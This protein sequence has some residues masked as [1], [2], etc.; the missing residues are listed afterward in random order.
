LI[1]GVDRRLGAPEAVLLVDGDGV[2]AFARNRLGDNRR[3]QRAPAGVDGFAG[4]EPAGEG[5][6]WERSHR[7]VIRSEV[8]SGGAGCAARSCAC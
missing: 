6:A 4:S 7:K 8:E 5:E 2:E 3:G 1:N